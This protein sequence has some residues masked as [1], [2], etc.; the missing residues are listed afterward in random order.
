MVGRSK[1]LKE[2]TDELGYSGVYSS[3][4]QFY[5]EKH[6]VH[7]KKILGLMEEIMIQDKFLQRQQL[8]G[9]GVG[10]KTKK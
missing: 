9:I 6:M 8:V 2:W 10:L 4:E 3:A 1:E 7:G 5:K